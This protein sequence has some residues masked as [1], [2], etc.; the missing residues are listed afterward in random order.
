MREALVRLNERLSRGAIG[1]AIGCLGLMTLIVLWTVFARYVLGAAPSWSEQAALFIMQWF[2]MA[3]A[4]AGVREGFHIRLSLLDGALS[5]HAQRGLAV[6]RNVL[7]GVF[8][9]AMAVYGGQLAAAT[10]PHAIPSLGIPRG[11]SYLPIVGAGLL[12]VLFAAERALAARR[13]DGE[14]ASWS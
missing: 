1:V 13:A 12:I 7:I 4:A 10:W 6:F 8:G 2:V 3:A 5:P 9:A 14:A 11:A